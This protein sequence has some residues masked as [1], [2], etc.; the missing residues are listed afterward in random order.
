LPEPQFHNLLQQL[1]RELS[2]AQLEKKADEALAREQWHIRWQCLE[3]LAEAGRRVGEKE[4]CSDW[5]SEHAKKQAEALAALLSREDI[6]QG[7]YRWAR[8]ALADLAALPVVDRA[9]LAELKSKL[10]DRRPALDYASFQV[11]HRW[12]HSNQTAIATSPVG[13]WIYIVERAGRVICRDLRTGNEYWTLPAARLT[14]L[15]AMAV[16]AV[17]ASGDLLAVGWEHKVDRTGRQVMVAGQTTQLWDLDKKKCRELVP[18]LPDDRAPLWEGL[19][20]SGADKLAC[21]LGNGEIV[22]VLDPSTGKELWRC[23]SE[24]S[25][26][27]HAGFSGDGRRLVLVAQEFAEVRDAADGKLLAK[28]GNHSSSS[29]MGWVAVSHDGRAAVFHYGKDCILYDLEKGTAKARFLLP[30]ESIQTVMFVLDDEGIVTA[31]YS[32]VLVWQ[33]PV[34]GRLQAIEARA[35]RAESGK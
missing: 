8:G 2:F 26:Y 4:Q 19:S 11:R 32:E 28:V 1:E 15:D 21:P 14:H 35:K 12:D 29:P 10:L 18:P 17:S 3:T 24:K 34:A 5:M 30:R 9:M 13:P 23:R 7:Q 27:S 31:G 25:G 20:S 33:D 6:D 16:L 22:S